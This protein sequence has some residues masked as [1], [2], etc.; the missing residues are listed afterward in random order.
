[1][2]I[3]REIAATP[4]IEQHDCRSIMVRLLL[5]AYLSAA[6][7]GLLWQVSISRDENG[8]ALFAL[9][10]NDALSMASDSASVNS[11]LS[12]SFL[13]QEIARSSVSN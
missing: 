11:V 5:H 8:N 3:Y 6:L 10:V 2:T 7:Y 4:S 12:D 13:A 1:M 9:S